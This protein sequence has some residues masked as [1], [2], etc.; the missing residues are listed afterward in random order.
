MQSQHRFYKTALALGSLLA[1]AAASAQ[2]TLYENNNFQG[3]SFTT[4]VD[5]DNLAY[6]GFN[7]RASSAVVGGGRLWE[8]CVDAEW[9]GTCRVL[10]P[11]QYPSLSSMGMNDRVSS[12]RALDR[13]ARPDPD[14]YAPPPLVSGD[15]RQRE[16]E[17][18]F[19]APVIATQAVYGAPGQ[20]CWIE[21]EQVV[22]E[23]T[24]NRLPSALLGAVLG[25]VLGHQLGGGSGRDLATV[26]GAVAGGALGA[27]IAGRGQDESL[28]TRDIQRCSTV[29]G[30]A[31][32]AY[33][34]V[35]YR[36]R[37]TVHHVQL[38]SAPGATV[39]VNQDGE[40]RN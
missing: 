10:R 17:R 36:F 40:P 6:R 15:Y 20:R 13:N 37:G 2:V 7:D 4:P 30:S 31:A 38:A 29:P 28:T 21:R 25:G 22:R 5:V 27:N 32:L 33:W 1:C 9:R 39:R 16:G 14:R 11:G 19:D 12:L 26:G 35:S 3:R 8:I 34:D 24:D 23:Q 18:L